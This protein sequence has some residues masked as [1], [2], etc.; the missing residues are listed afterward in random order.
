MAITQG[1]YGSG[2][3]F[4]VSDTFEI[5]WQGDG[6]S[7]LEFTLG[8]ETGLVTFRVWY[9]LSTGEYFDVPVNAGE[10]EKIV[11]TT[12]AGFKLI[13][14]KSADSGTPTWFPSA[15]GQ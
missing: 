2:E 11:S 3:S 5:I 6:F 8:A 9:G 15:L 10:R 12:V 7:P 1:L 13:Q 4:A 14:A